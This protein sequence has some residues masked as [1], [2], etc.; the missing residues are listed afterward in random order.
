EETFSEARKLYGYIKMLD[1]Q[2]VQLG[3][4]L[5]KLLYDY[6]APW[7]VY[8]RHGI[9]KWMLRLLV[10]YPDGKQV[11][12]AGEAQIS[13]IKGISRSRAKALLSKIAE[14]EKAPGPLGRA[15]ITETAR[16]I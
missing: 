1:K 10:D 7:M 9:P 13:K 8:T 14:H 16:Q 4:Q 12:E 3:N 5:E 2:Q 11:G 15:T 6:F